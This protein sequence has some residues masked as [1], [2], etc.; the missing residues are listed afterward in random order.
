MDYKDNPL[1]WDIPAAVNRAPMEEAEKAAYEENIHFQ[2]VFS[3]AS[4][5]KVLDW[6]IK[7]TLDTPTWLPGRSP[8]VGY[9]REGQN[10][11]VR[12]IK[13]KIEKAKNYKEQP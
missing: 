11:L 4:G 1:A 13:S 7:H 12:Q 2:R 9:F 10:N 8:D 3:T 6:M 5:R